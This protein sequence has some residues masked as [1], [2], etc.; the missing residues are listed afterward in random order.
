MQKSVCDM[1]KTVTSG[2]ALL[3]KIM[4]SRF[5]IWINIA[6]AHQISDDII[7]RHDILPR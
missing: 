1:G 3:G 2:K 5:P 7:D 4:F 6:S